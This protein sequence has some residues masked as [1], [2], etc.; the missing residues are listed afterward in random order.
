VNGQMLPYT[1]G[2]PAGLTVVTP[3]P[4]Y[5]KGNYNVQQTAT[6]PSDA[7]VNKTVDTYP[8]ALMADSITVLSSAWSDSYNASTLLTARIPV[9][10]TINA[11]MLE[12][13]VPSNPGIS[14]NY[15]GGVENFMRLEENWSGASPLW[16]NG[17]IVV[18]FYSQYATST[19]QAPGVYYQVPTRD[20]AFDTNFTQQVKIPPMTP[21]VKAIIRG[22][23][24]ATAQ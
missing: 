7:G 15:S 20:W 3:F 18:L 4:M 23:W 14:G 13:I 21:E 1:A 12:G 24:T 8:A 9:T 17:A 16:Y 10:T 19:W 5:V 6:G 22:Q 11:G 2:V